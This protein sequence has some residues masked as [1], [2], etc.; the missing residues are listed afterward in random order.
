MTIPPGT[1]WGKGASMSA[2]LNEEAKKGLDEIRRILYM[3]VL[4]PEAG[5]HAAIAGTLVNALLHH[6]AAPALDLRGQGFD[7]VRQGVLATVTGRDASWAYGLI[8]EIN[9]LYDGETPTPPEA[10]V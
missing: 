6:A 4:A 3:A 2:E 5:R 10:V 8:Q 1:Y 7:G 9:G